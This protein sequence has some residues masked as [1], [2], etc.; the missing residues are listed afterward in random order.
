MSD[1]SF[2]QNLNSLTNITTK[3]EITYESDYAKLN[4]NN[5]IR[6]ILMKDYHNNNLAFAVSS[7]KNKKEMPFYI[8]QNEPIGLSLIKSK[9][10]IYKDI[11]EIYYGYS[12]YLEY[13]FKSVD[14]IW[15][16]KYTLYYKNRSIITI[17][18]FFSPKLINFLTYIKH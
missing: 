10:D 6:E 7:W 17:K 8:P 18:E 4:H 2:T 3:I 16:R 13:T 9:I 11:H 14:A 5:S 1:G 15:G 12:T